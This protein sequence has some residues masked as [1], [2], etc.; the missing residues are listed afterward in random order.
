VVG[1]GWWWWVVVV[2]GGRWWLVVGGGW[3]WWVV[4]VGGGREGVRWWVVDLA[5]RAGPG[6]ARGAFWRTLV[7]VSTESVMRT[8]Y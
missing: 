2:G 4:V 8:F 5:S 6:A 7:E 3:W 1:G